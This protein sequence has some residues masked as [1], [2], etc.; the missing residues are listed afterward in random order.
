M[1]MTDDEVV[2]ALAPRVSPGA[3]AEFRMLQM[4]FGVTNGKL[5]PGRVLYTPVPC[6]DG[7]FMAVSFTLAEGSQVPSWE[8]VHGP[9]TLA[10]LKALAGA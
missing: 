4:R 9:M 7:N 2:E 10:D 8:A 6:P 1:S 5:A 3:L